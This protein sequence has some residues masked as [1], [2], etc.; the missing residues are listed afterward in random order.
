MGWFQ[1]VVTGLV[2]ATLNLGNWI[3]HPG[4]RHM[5]SLQSIIIIIS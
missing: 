3:G 4:A 5:S 2:I 1:P